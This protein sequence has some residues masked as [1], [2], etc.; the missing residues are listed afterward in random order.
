MCILQCM[1]N[2]YSQNVARFPVSEDRQ[3]LEEEGED[4]EISH[5]CHSCKLN[6]E[7][8]SEY[9]EHLNDDCM[10]GKYFLPTHFRPA[11]RANSNIMR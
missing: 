7:T 11:L 2:D 4:E 1:C 10:T 5:T 8:L 3:S 6:F 9:L